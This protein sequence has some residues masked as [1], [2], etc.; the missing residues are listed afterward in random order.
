ML[1]GGGGPSWAEEGWES[2]GEEFGDGGAAE[3]AGNSCDGEK[4]ES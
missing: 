1:D 4:Q 3:R 2:W